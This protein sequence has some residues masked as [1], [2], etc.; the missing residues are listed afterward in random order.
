MIDE[1]KMKDAGLNT[2]VVPTSVTRKAA[3]ASWWDGV[4]FGFSMTITFLVLVVVV[5]TWT[6]GITWK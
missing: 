2:W 5:A 4:M 6:G 1:H 3:T